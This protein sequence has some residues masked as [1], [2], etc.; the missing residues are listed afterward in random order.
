LDDDGFR[1]LISSLAES[2]IDVAG[3]YRCDRP[4]DLDE[5]DARIRGC[6]A[7]AEE[8]QAGDHEEKR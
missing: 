7:L 6:A 1:A 4:I 2:T 8:H 3:H 5:V